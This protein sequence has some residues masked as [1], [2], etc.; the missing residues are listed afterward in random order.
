MD[1]LAHMDSKITSGK[2]PLVSEGVSWTAH[3]GELCNLGRKRSGMWF[4]NLHAAL[5]MAFQVMWGYCCGVTALIETKPSLCVQ[6]RNLAQTEMKN[7]KAI[8]VE[9]SDFVMVADS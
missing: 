9:S 3:P 6:E 5:Q 8:S 4:G 7:W 1:D 2:V